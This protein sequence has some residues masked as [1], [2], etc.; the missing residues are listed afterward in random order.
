MVVKTPKDVDEETCN[1]E[2][3]VQISPPYQQI[4]NSILLSSE[5]KHWKMG[6]ADYWNAYQPQR[7]VTSSIKEPL[8]EMRSASSS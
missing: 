4:E 3:V 6:K 1:W 7:Y 8:L 5:R 2:Q